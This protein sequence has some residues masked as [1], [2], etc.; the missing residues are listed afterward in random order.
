MCFLPETEGSSSL[1]AV[2]V[3][4]SR[5]IRALA[6]P[7]TQGIPTSDQAIWQLLAALQIE[8]AAEAKAASASRLLIEE[9][10]VARVSLLLDLHA[11]Q[12]KHRVPLAIDTNR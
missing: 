4:A 2:A 12:G 10:Q 6:N 11:S 9:M 5:E 3:A 7:S 8:L 1:T